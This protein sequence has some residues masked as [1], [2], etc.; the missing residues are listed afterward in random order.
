MNRRGLGSSGAGV[1]APGNVP[2]IIEWWQADLGVD[3]AA[4]V[5]WTG[6][7]AGYV[8]EEATNYPDVNSADATLNGLQ[9]I[10]FVAANTD[11]LVLTGGP[12]R[13]APSTQS[14]YL[15]LLLKQDTWG[16]AAGIFSSG[17]Q[18]LAIFQS[19]STPN[20]AMNNNATVNANAGAVVTQWSAV[21]ALFSGSTGDSLI[22]QGTTAT[23]SS[24]GVNNPGTTWVLGAN[25]GQTTFSGITVYFAAIIA[26]N[27][28]SGAI[29]KLD[30]YLASRIGSSTPFT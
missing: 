4:G 14:T 26:G 5:A 15:Y 29:S 10:S 9:T 17:T 18:N 2:G 23:G 6:Q 30:G 12:D 8:L 13:P 28:G 11:R 7:L 22:C 25:G 16:S 27:P 3:T 20:I 19:G 24:A 1:F 21:R